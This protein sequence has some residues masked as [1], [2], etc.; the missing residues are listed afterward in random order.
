V[1]AKEVRPRRRVTGSRPRD[2]GL[3]ITERAT[4]LVAELLVEQRR[5]VAEE[6]A[7]LLT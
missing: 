5:L 3:I 1:A 4:R 7:A 2:L 6:V